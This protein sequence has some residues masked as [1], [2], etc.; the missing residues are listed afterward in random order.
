LTLAGDGIELSFSLLPPAPIADL[1]N[2]VWV[3][4]SLI[5]GDSVSGVAG[6]RATL[7]LFTDGSMLGSTGCRSLNGRYLVSG[8]EIL[9]NEL[10]AQGDCPQELQAQDGVVVNVLGDG[11]RAMVEG[12]TLTLSKAGSQ[13][14]VYR[15]EG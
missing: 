10:A 9:I 14:L 13:G 12:N 6:E 11:F 2:T 4:Q 3:L 8:A 15:A 7:E 1:T 5:E